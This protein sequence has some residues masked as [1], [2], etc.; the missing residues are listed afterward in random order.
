M[1][2]HLEGTGAADGLPVPGC[3]CVR[4]RTAA[5]TGT[6]R[7]PLSAVVDG[8]L[9]LH[10]AGATC[11]DGYAVQETGDGWSVVEPDGTR[12]LWAPHGAS[13]PP[14]SPYDLVLLGFGDISGFA[15]HVAALRRGGA[16][17]AAT[18]V[19]AVGIGHAAPPAEELAPLFQG[20]GV[21]L[22]SDGDLLEI[23]SD[24]PPP[25]RAA[26]VLVLGGARSGKS[27]YAELRVAA[28]PDVTYV[29]TAPER[30]GDLE[31]EARVRAHVR[32]RPLGWTTME[33]AEVAGVLTSSPPAVLVDDL[34][35]WL[36]RL[37]DAQDGWD[38]AIPAAVEEAGDRLV[39]AWR[40]YAGLAVL[41]TPE[42][43]A[44]VVPATSSGRRFRDLLGALT[45][46]LA[47]ESDEVV[48]V[49][50]GLPRRLR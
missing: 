25:S 7:A 13:P 2:V 16:A 30:P 42:V 15:Q 9:R 12:L 35:L 28:E 17:G 32:R 14:A 27:A 19:C 48:Q 4:C 43:G 34:G 5:R 22:A 50:A 46:R 44:G 33:T 8:Q 39:G 31:W 21:E 29:A 18:R 40:E 24:Y 26:H 20:W 10:P 37:L 6:S 41:V 1:R 3:H 47:A 11:V 38:G 36:A 23:P 45:A 49:V